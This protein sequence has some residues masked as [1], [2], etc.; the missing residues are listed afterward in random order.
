MSKNLFQE[1]HCLFTN[2]VVLLLKD[3]S[4]RRNCNKKQKWTI[5]RASSSGRS[6]CGW[7][8]HCQRQLQFC[9]WERQSSYGERAYGVMI[10]RILSEPMTV[11]LSAEPRWTYMAFLSSDGT[12]RRFVCK[13]AFW[14]DTACWCMRQWDGTCRSWWQQK[15]F[16]KLDAFLSDKSLA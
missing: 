3:E 10:S 4:V 13:N 15:E 12:N 14:N 11:W 6:E 2:A 7:S 8:S 5:S 1:S 16:L 9:P